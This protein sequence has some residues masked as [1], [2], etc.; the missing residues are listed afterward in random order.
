MAKGYNRY[1][2][3][4]KAKA[5]NEV[6]LEHCENKT[7]MDIYREHIKEQFFISRATFY[8]YLAIPY[9]KELAEFEKQTV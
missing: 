8:N 3:L 4:K 6:Y 5:V 1:N 2:L 9:K 7:L